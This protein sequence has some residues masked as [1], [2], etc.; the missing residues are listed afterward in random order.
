[1]LN[2]DPPRPDFTAPLPIFPDVLVE[3]VVDRIPVRERS[4]AVVDGADAADPVEFAHRVSRRVQST[5]RACDVID[6]HDFVRPASLRFEYSH[7]DE[8]SYRTAWFDFNAVHREI[9]SPL[10]SN[11]R[12]SYL[13]RLWDEAA[14]RS[15]RAKLVVAASDQVLII[16]G[17]MMLGRIADPSAVVHLQLS[18]G[19]LRRQ[20]RG[21]QHWTIEPLLRFYEEYSDAREGPEPDFTVRWDHPERPAILPRSRT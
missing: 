21:D 20:T 2:S 18:P 16:A 9:V 11:G 15:A 14:D 17:P 13:P 4:I 19:A 10:A 7:T 5:G 6:L 3:S 12:G 1:M 8:L